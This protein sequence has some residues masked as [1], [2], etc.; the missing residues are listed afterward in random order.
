MHSQDLFDINGKQ[1][2]IKWR[3]TVVLIDVLN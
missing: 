1:I 2:T 3:R